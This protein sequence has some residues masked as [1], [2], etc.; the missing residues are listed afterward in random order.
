MKKIFGLIVL[1]LLLFSFSLSCCTYHWNRTDIRREIS[2]V[3]ISN[4][5]L[6]EWGNDRTIIIIKTDNDTIKILSYH[7]GDNDILMYA[8]ENDTIKMNIVIA[9]FLIKEEEF[10]LLHGNIISLNFCY[11]EQLKVNDNIIYVTNHFK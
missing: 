10:D 1:L 2:G 9:P 5:R 4:I 6:F 7:D 3:V 11:M 8:K